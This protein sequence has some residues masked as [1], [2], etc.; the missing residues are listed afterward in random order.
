[1]TKYKKEYCEMLLSHMEEGLSFKSF[2]GVIRASRATLYNWAE[3]YPEFEEAKEIGDSLS[4][5][6]WEKL[7]VD[8]AKGNIEGFNSASW[9][10]NMKNRHDWRDR[11]DV[12][13]DIK[14]TLT[15]EQVV[16]EARGK[17]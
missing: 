14:G 7:G 12:S 8:A 15:L 13:A 10:F 16:A 4:L 5:L 3:K 6:W 1:M 9:I 2:A 11:K 17:K